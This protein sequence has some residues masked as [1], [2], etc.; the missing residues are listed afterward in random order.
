MD[1][2][3]QNGNR[4]MLEI[5]MNEVEMDNW[6]KQILIF[7][8]L[9]NFESAFEWTEILRWK[10]HLSIFINFYEFLSFVSIYWVFL[11]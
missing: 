9:E 5:F 10:Q 11:S 4:P 3:S 6:S 7:K 2:S 1:Q 8:K